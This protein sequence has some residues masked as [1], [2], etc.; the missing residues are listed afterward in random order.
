MSN[1]ESRDP[2]AAFV[3]RRVL[4]VDSRGTRWIGVLRGLTYSYITLDE[5]L[6]LSRAQVVALKLTAK[7]E[8]AGP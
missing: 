6:V 5:D 2:Y 8:G 4:V 7:L 1:G 3:G